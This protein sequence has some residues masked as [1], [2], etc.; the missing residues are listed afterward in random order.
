MCFCLKM[1]FLFSAAAICGTAYG[2]TP[3]AGPAAAREIRSV[4]RADARTGR[5]IRTVVVS[6]PRG[7]S[8]R[9]IKPPA[10]VSEII[11]ETARR[12]DVDP[13]LVHSMIQVESNYDPYAVSVKGAQGLMQLMPETARRFGVSNTFDVRQNVE[14]GVRYLRFLTDLFP[15]NPKLALA[16]YNA[17]EGAVWKYNNR[18]PPY[19]ETEQ[20]VLKVGKR[21]GEARLA[22]AAKPAVN[23]GTRSSEAQES[24]PEYASV[25][26][27]IDSDGRLHLETARTP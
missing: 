22:A 16:A 2:A 4:V 10:G 14:G 13:L 18:V 11:E 15:E 3:G 26:Y 17:G 1:G 23:K 27:F 5:L 19:P 8:R 7:G 25:R 6:P 20:Y 9:A 21:Y 12:Y 24:R